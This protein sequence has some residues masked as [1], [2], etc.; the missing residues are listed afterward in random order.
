MLRIELTHQFADFAL[1]VEITAGDGITMLFGPSGAGKSTIAKSVGGLLRTD[2]AYVQLGDRVL[3]DTSRRVWLKPYARRIGYVFQEPHLFPHLS[4]QGNLL[5][6]AGRDADLRRIADLLDIT[7]LLARRP[8][9]L[10]GGEAAR[11]ALGRALLSTP[12]MLI[13]D[14]PLAALDARRKADIL[15]YLERLRD[16][17]NVPMLYI[18]HALDEVARLG[19]TLVLLRDGKVARSG[20]V[21]DV[22]SDP[23]AVPVLGPRMAGAMLE[24]Q[25][26]R[27]VDGLTQLAVSGGLVWVPG[28]AGAVGTKMRL[29]VMA[30]DVIVG[31][32][33]PHGLSALNILPAKVVSLYRGDG[34]GALVVLQSGAD[35]LLA[36]I[37]QRSLDEMGLAP[38]DAVYGIL[39]TVSVGPTDVFA[40][41]D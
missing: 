23:D 21:K 6:G 40:G 39:K 7:P 33:K 24:G 15:P 34:P 3:A 32:H 22:L 8:A 17:A 16:H 14:E 25:V 10:S 28:T 19:S 1:D 31:T 35:R 41:M 13:L 18:T 37:T 38:G 27:H 30:Q 36:R 5:Y 12:S 11:V 9:G 4:V 20:S 29:R 2:Q 26:V